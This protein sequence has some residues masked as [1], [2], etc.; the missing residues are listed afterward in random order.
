MSRP[1]YTLLR[2]NGRSVDITDAVLSC[3]ITCGIRPQPTGWVPLLASGSIT[4]DPAAVSKAGVPGG[5]ADYAEPLRLTVSVGLRAIWDVEVL[6]QF[7]SPLAVAGAGGAGALLPARWRI[8]NRSADAWGRPFPYRHVSASDVVADYPSPAEFAADMMSAHDAHY[9][10][11]TPYARASTAAGV[12]WVYPAVTGTLA[13]NVALI[14]SAAA[15]VPYALPT[16][17]VGM[18]RLSDIMATVYPPRP[19]MA[20]IYEGG[21]GPRSAMSTAYPTSPVGYRLG[22]SKGV[23]AGP[24]ETILRLPMTA[25]DRDPDTGVF[26]AERVIDIPHAPGYVDTL[27]RT[28]PDA[29]SGFTRVTVAVEPIGSTAD[30]LTVRA[31]APARNATATVAIQGRRIQ[32]H[33]VE[34]VPVAPAGADDDWLNVHSWPWANWASAQPADL[35][36]YVAVVGALNRPKPLARLLYPLI[37]GDGQVNLYGNHRTPGVA[38][39]FRVAPGLHLRGMVTTV[40]LV[41]RRGASAR[42]VIGVQDLW[43]IGIYEG[44]TPGVPTPPTPPVPPSQPKPVARWG[45]STWG[46]GDVWA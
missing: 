2:A 23:A 15:A 21:I 38:N 45:R 46:G 6:P 29:P 17:H 37:D 16:G 32:R 14:A 4:V 9:G 3:E 25:S 41:D 10:V 43:G 35:T 13:Q 33:D 42:L 40:G 31:E 34:T 26:L 39:I 5:G 27:Y 7:A 44:S 19:D 24:V 8:Q 22:G 1:T 11:T 28:T 18:S 36:A 12:E 20:A 30:R